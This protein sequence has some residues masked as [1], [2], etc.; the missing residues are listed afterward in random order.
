MS[1][2]QTLNID[3]VGTDERVGRISL[4]R[5][6]K[7]NALSQELLYEFWDALHEMEADS[8]IRTIIVKGEGR[9]FSAG[10]DLTPSRG[11]ADAVVRRHRSVDDKGRRLLMGIR[12]GMQQ[13][14]DIHMY[15]WNMAKITIAQV[16]GYAV[17]GGCELA[18]MADLVVAADDAQLGHP[19]LR[20]LGTSRTGVIWPL[21]IGM[22]KAKELYYTG[23]NVTGL[24]AEEIG[25]INY[26]WPLDELDKH[27]IA[28]A[29]RIAIMSAD[30]LAILKL[31]MNRF[32]ENM[33]IY[34]SVRSST[35]LDAAGQFTEFSYDYQDQMREGG[36]RQAL[37]WRD[38][39]FRD[40]DTY[41][42][43]RGGDARVGSKRAKAAKSK[44]GARKKP[45]SKKRPAAKKRPAK[46]R[47]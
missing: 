44:A 24:E 13:I 23:E 29:D 12:T 36:L 43:K 38:D 4:N 1:D 6:E 28:L 41:K 7:L 21:V 26:S 11:G 5:P 33:G 31:N 39:P 35:D 22:R 27:T 19:G 15:F 37:K 46:K 17:A 16:H 10:Y 45:A 30:H 25:M 9:A 34:S 2:Y 47:K 8:S 20:G 14:T 42:K 3:R 18:M 32:Y 40:S